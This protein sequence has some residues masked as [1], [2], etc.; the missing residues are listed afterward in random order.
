MLIKL[1]VKNIEKDFV[2]LQNKNSEELKIKKENLSEEIKI[3]EEIKINLF[4]KEEQDQKTLGK[5]ILNEILNTND[6]K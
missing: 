1:K 4:K 5:E 3:G 6:N 2:Y